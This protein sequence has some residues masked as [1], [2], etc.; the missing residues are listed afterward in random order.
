MNHSENKNKNAACEKIMDSYLTLDK[1][2]RIPLKITLHLLKC[3]KCRTQVRYLNMA[4]KI[5]CAPV[6]IETPLTDKTINSIMRKI[7]PEW[8][9]PRKNPVSMTK[10]IVGG[11]LMIL[12]MLV[13]GIFSKVFV[14]EGF[15]IAFYLVFAGSVTAYCAIF[16]GCNLDCFI[17]KIETIRLNSAK[18]PSSI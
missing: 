14:N 18:S 15:Q 10:W 4:E 6:K 3:E 8:T 1:N 2:E 13:F 5:A 12:F 17:K 9:F 16:V 11:I 7:N